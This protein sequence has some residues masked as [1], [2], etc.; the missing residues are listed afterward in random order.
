[1]LLPAKKKV[2]SVVGTK[3]TAMSRLDATDAAL[4]GR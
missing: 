1:M 4:A 3:G 2:E